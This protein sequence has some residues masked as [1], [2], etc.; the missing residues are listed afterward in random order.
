MKHF[1]TWLVA[2]G[3]IVGLQSRVHSQDPCDVIASLHEHEHHHHDDHSN[4][5]DDQQVPCDSSHDDRCPTDHHHHHNHD[6]LCH[7]MHV[8]DAMAGRLRLKVPDFSLSRFRHEG[9]VAPEGPCLGEDKP[10][11]I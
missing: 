2:L 8:T 1:I 4:S 3:I 11:L 10:P 5:P 7:G 9:E 6:C